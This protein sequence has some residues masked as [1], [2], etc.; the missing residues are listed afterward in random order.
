[1]YRA[2]KKFWI[3]RLQCRLKTLLYLSSAY[4]DSLIIFKSLARLSFADCIYVLK[5]LGLTLFAQCFSLGSFVRLHLHVS[6]LIMRTSP[7]KHR[8]C[9]VLAPRFSLKFCTRVFLCF[10]CFAS[11]TPGLCSAF[12]SATFEFVRLCLYAC[13][14]HVL[15]CALCL[16]NIGFVSTFPSGSP[17]LNVCTLMFVTFCYGHFP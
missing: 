8:V 9:A 3:R 15:L 17:F 11:Q 7:N 2:D 13:V 1:M 5:I 16:T 10:A 14:C 4:C 6:R 12:P